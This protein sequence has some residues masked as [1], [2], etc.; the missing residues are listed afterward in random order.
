VTTSLTIESTALTLQIGDSDPLSLTLGAVVAFVD[1]AG[2]RVVLTTD[3]ELDAAAS[4]NTYV[5]SDAEIVV[6]LPASEDIGSALY[7]ARFVLAYAQ[8]LRVRAQGDDVIRWSGVA[9]AEAGYLE[10]S[11]RDAVVDVEYIG[12]GVFTVTGAQ[13]EWSF[14]P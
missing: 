1:G 14:G 4:G 13:R 10:T 9:S 12:G 5:N 11:D 6:D 3:T 2:S 8:A 7:R